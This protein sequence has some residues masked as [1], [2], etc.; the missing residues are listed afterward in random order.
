[1]ISAY[2]PK[3]DCDGHVHSLRYNRHYTKTSYINIDKQFICT[4]VI[5]FHLLSYKI[6]KNKARPIW[7]EIKIKINCIMHKYVKYLL[8]IQRA[9]IQN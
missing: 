6:S 1:M 5:N 7:S 8:T 3:R 4:C 9:K 2:R